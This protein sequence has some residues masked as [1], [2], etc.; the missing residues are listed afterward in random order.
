MEFRKQP[1]SV[2]MTALDSQLQRCKESH[3]LAMSGEL[4]DLV[5]MGANMPPLLGDVVCCDLS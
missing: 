1:M 2:A 4:P 5:S 3:T